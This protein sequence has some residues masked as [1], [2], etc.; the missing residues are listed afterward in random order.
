MQELFLATIGLSILIAILIVAS[1]G[2]TVSRPLAELSE[3]MNR[4]SKGVL[5]NSAG[6]ERY[7][8]I[9]QLADAINRLRKTL[10][11]R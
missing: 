2:R 6:I 10:Q 3:V 9:A 4:I 1:I 11:R 7:N 5:S 8:V